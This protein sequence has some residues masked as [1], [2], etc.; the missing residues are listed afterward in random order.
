MEK[1]IVLVVTTVFGA[2]GWWIGDFIG[3][4]TAFVLSIVGTA[5]GVYLARRFAQEYLP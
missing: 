3:T 4:F 2:V 1:M 5:A